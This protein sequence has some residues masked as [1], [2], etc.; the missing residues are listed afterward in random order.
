MDQSTINPPTDGVYCLMT[1]VAG[2]DG[3]IVGRCIT[4]GVASQ[5]ASSYTLVSNTWYRLKIQVNAAATIVT[6]T[7]Y[8]EAGA[9]LWTDTVNSNIPTSAGRET[10]HGFVAHNTGTS[11]VLLADI[12]YINVSIGRALVR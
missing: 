1:N 2:T 4:N 8:S 10:G 7:L 12:D 5:T 6:F 9:T 3:V 11:A